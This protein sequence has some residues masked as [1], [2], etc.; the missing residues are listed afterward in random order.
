[1]A[2]G[3]PTAQALICKRLPCARKGSGYARTQEGTFCE[4]MTNY[5]LTNV[6]FVQNVTH[7]RFFSSRDHEFL[8]QKMSAKA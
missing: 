1:M 7:V 3:M 8:N 4:C 5:S 6:N 2:H